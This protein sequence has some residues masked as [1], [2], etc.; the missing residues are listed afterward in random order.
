MA[1]A[2]PSIWR[3][4]HLRRAEYEY[5]DYIEHLISL[6]LVKPSDSVGQGQVASA[7]VALP[8]VSTPARCPI[9]YDATSVSVSAVAQSLAVPTVDRIRETVGG[10]RGKGEC[11]HTLGDITNM[12]VQVSSQPATTGD[13]VLR[14]RANARPP[15]VGYVLLPRHR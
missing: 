13:R 2:A 8:Q 6:G 15:G 7:V 9:N 5:S 11:P 10:S 14:K 3:N 12:V 1:S 4:G